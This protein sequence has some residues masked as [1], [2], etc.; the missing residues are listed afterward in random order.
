[1]P[2]YILTNEAADLLP[3]DESP[4]PENGNPHPQNFVG[5]VPPAGNWVPPADNVWEDWN[6]EM[7]ADNVP[8]PAWEQQAQLLNQ[9][10][11]V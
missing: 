7:A 1:L 6:E 5:P 11:Q 9:P 8:N 10:P 3:G 2:V 4:P